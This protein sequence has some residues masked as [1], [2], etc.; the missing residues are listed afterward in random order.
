MA[1]LKVLLIKTSSMGDIIHTFPAITELKKNIKNIQIDWVVEES[2]VDILKLREDIN[3]VIL[4]D[5][6][7][8]RKNWFKY[9]REIKKFINI[10]KQEQY[11]Y[12]VDAQGLYKSII[13]TS[14]AKVKKKN[15]YGYD[16]N[17]IRGKY[18]S[19]I[20]NKK[21]YIPK[22]QHAIYRIQE[23]FSK[24]F[25]YECIKTLYPNYGILNNDK[26]NVNSDFYNK[27][28]LFL[29]NTTWHTKKWPLDNWIELGKLLLSNNYNII[30]NSGN[31]LEY[32]EAKL[33]KKS[34]NCNDKIIILN[35]E[36][37]SNKIQIIQSC[38]FVVSVDTGLGHIAVALEKRLVAI[39]GA[40]SSVLTGML[41]HNITNFEASSKKYSCSPCI[42]KVCYKNTQECYQDITVKD[43]FSVI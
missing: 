9:F 4:V 15:K 19:W 24:I 16:K 40:T 42:S 29:P 1:R 37:L 36:N 28:I 30:I 14:L 35:S 23:L 6:R 12:I 21:V 3:K 11:D 13:I 2:F 34:L 39:Y 41:G 38:S 33:I 31:D 20:Y 10:L 43:V 25:N 7:K 26:L 17:S 22:D 27:S 32:K 18:I 8:W 5:T